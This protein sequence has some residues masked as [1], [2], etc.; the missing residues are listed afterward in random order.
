VF[1]FT[2]G[3]AT[4]NASQWETWPW[5]K[6]T[7]LAAFECLGPAGS[8]RENQCHEKGRS[9]TPGAP[10]HGAGQQMFCT[11]HAHGARVL[12]W[13]YGGIYGAHCP[14]AEYYKWWETKDVRVHNQSAVRDWAARSASCVVAQGFDGILLDMET[15]GGPPIGPASERTLITAAVCELRAALNASLP[16]AMLAWTVDTG[17]YFDFKEMTDRRCVDLWL[18]MD[19]SRCES[20][21]KHSLTSNRAPAPISFTAAVV[22][23]Y[24][25]KGVPVNRLGI[26]FPWFGCI[27]PCSLEPGS[28]Y[29]GCPA[30]TKMSGYP[31]FG[32]VLAH[33]LPNMTSAHIA[34]NKTVQAKYFNYRTASNATNQVWFD[35]KT[36]LLLSRK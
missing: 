13:G 5:E 30:V 21:E 27:Y 15:I 14:V 25:A 31:T 18:D 4:I 22:Q 7:T 26:V 16:G 2:Q 28:D 34:W 24:A 32:D 19:Y 6:I 29:G 20:E 3:P 12:T 17:F 1:A 33:F 11:A 10:V 9:Y 8:P 23:N 36:L 35:G